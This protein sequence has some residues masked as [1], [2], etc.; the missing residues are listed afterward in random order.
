MD[1]STS[2]LGGIDVPE[3]DESL[4]V[5]AFKPAT[6]VVGV[7]AST[8]G[9]ESMQ[10]LLAPL[11]ADTGLA[12][13][14]VQHLDAEHPSLLAE[15]LA[16]VTRMQV[17]E[18]VDGLTVLADHVYVMPAHADVV[19]ADGAFHLISRL[20]SV[21]AHLPVDRFFGSLAEEFG[22]RSV[23]VVLS[24]GG[25]DGAV[26]VRLVKAAGGVTFAQSAQEAASASMPTAAV[27]SG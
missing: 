7:G 9:L 24:G 4:A 21:G 2:T 10:L 13:V 16:R 23:A 17:L 19:L 25:A 26:G 6:A 20:E 27:A 15:I 1:D 11:P 18:V 5:D 8:G 3:R 14:F 22:S 12:F